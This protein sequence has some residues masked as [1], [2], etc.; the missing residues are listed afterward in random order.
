MD[1]L[2]SEPQIEAVEFGGMLDVACK[3]NRVV[4]EGVTEDEMVGWYHRLSEHE[5]EQTPGDSAAVRGVAKS[6]T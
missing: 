4:I 3:R 2:P 1:S 6:W 5:F